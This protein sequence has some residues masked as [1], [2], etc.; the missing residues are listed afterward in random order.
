MTEIHLNIKGWL[1]LPI[2]SHKWPV[3]YLHES[4][5]FFFLIV[6]LGISQFLRMSHFSWV[7]AVTTESK[8]KKLK[9]IVL[10]DSL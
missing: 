3:L 7:H 8:L 6:E 9:Y 2:Y 1:S 5:Q 10:S 4:N